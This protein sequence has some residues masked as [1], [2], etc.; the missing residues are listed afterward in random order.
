MKGNRSM[1]IRKDSLTATC[2]DLLLAKDCVANLNAARYQ[3]SVSIQAPAQTDL[4]DGAGLQP[5]GDAVGGPAGRGLVIGGLA[6]LIVASVTAILVDAGALVASIL[7]VAIGLGGGIGAF[8]G[9]RRARRAL[10]SRTPRGDQNEFSLHC[11]GT[12]EQISV[13]RRVLGRSPCR[14]LRMHDH[15]RDARRSPDPADS[16]GAVA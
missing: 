10:V 12:P 7:V 5:Y 6:G 3:G 1:A 9:W 14:N 16:P 13:A 11:V 15:G 2:Q 4:L 8:T